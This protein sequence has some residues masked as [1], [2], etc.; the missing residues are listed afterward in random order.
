MSGIE[1]GKGEKE[2]VVGMADA[3][4]FCFRKETTMRETNLEKEFLSGK[5]DG[6]LLY[7]RKPK[8]TES[9][10]RCATYFRKKEA[11]VAYEDYEP[12]YASGNDKLL[13]LPD[14]QIFEKIFRKY[15]LFPPASYTARP[16]EI[17]D[18]ILLR[19]DGKLS[20]RYINFISDT[21][22]THFVDDA[23]AAYKLEGSQW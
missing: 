13:Y 23:V 20:A 15:S 3:I 8:E 4:P 1:L 17:G 18:V 7:I 10:F 19:R 11:D 14:D 9:H 12:V 21:K 5:E 16:M 6:Y 22:L 2:E